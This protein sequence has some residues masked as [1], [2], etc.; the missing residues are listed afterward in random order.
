[1]K[2]GRQLVKGF[3]Q[4]L[5]PLLPEP[6]YRGDFIYCYSHRPCLRAST[7]LI[8]RVCLPLGRKVVHRR[9]TVGLGKRFVKRE[10]GP[11]VD[12]RGVDQAPENDP[13]I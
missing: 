4:D 1:M 11:S 6:H 9:S 5:D 13:D 3:I 8:L 10:K 2:L 12:C 7:L